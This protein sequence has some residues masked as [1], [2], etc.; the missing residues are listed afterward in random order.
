MRPLGICTRA[1]CNSI[2]RIATEIGRPCLNHYCIGGTY[3]ATDPEEWVG[4]A[5]CFGGRVSTRGGRRKLCASC[6]GW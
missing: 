3:R 1:N 4:C 5:E 2:T 6:G